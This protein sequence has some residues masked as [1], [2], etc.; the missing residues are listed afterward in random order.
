[1]GRAI[2][3]DRRIDALEI[4]V[5]EILSILDELSK[6]NSKQTQVDLHEARNVEK[7]IDE[8]SG[9]SSKQSDNGKSKP[10]AKPRSSSKDSK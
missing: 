6:T 8:G 9:D 1:M 3:Q 4:K 7:S 10:K 2:D 5:S